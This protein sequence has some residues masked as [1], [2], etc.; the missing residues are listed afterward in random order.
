MRSLTLVLSS[1]KNINETLFAL[2]ERTMFTEEVV[3]VQPSSIVVHTEDKVR[4]DSHQRKGVSASPRRL[5]D[6]SACRN[7]TQETYLS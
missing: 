1:M 4:S 5:L 2:F 7:R 6:M 3:Q